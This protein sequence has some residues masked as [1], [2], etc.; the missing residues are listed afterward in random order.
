MSKHLVSTEEALALRRLLENNPFSDNLAYDQKLNK[1]GNFP[2]RFK[3]LEAFST[4][5]TARA[6]AAIYFFGDTTD[7]VYETADVVDDSSKYVSA[8]SGDRGI[9]IASSEYFVALIY[10][11]SESSSATRYMGLASTDYATTDA[12]VVLDNLEPMNGVG[13]TETTL[14]VNNRFAWS[15]DN[16]ADCC[17]DYNQHTSEFDLIQVK[18]T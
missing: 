7:N 13:T 1:Q 18:C 4:D 3:L 15:I 17:A 5:G 8:S 6:N 12:T 11:V 9:C 14:S 16:N 10:N 2:F